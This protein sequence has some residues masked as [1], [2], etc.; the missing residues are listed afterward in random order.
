MLKLV[1]CKLDFRLVNTAHRNSLYY[2]C[3]SYMSLKEFQNKGLKDF[4]FRLQHIKNLEVTNSVIFTIRNSWK[5]GKSTTLLG[6]N[7]EL[8]SQRSQ[9]NHILRDIVVCLPRAEAATSY[10]D[11]TNY[12]TINKVDR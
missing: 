3:N 9:N 5:N 8:R 2:V 11:R 7:T 6:S 12:F 4:W 1:K 10:T